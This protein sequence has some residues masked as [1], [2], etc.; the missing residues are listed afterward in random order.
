MKRKIMTL[1][2]V[3]FFLGLLCTAFAQGSDP[4]IEF[5]DIP[6]NGDGIEPF[7]MSITE[8]T[9]QQYVNFLNAALRENKI[10]VGPVEPLNQMSAP[11]YPPPF[12]LQ[13]MR[14]YKSKYQQLVYDEYG[15]RILNL[16][17][18]RPT[19]D[20]NEDGIV[21]RWEVKNPLNRCWIEYDSDKE[22]FRVVNP[23]KVDWDKYFDSD[24]LPAGIPVVDSITNW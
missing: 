5:A 22:R 1:A 8:I 19:V 13:K 4:S 12:Y 6:G 3:V 24:N 2:P 18:I 20:H 14:N 7:K 9:N 16:L 11:P 10:T 23:K 21:E 15:N 17:N